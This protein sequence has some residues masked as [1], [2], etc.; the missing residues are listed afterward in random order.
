MST[1]SFQA[2]NRV[3]QAGEALLMRHWPHVVTKHPNG[4]RGVDF[5]DAT[6]ALIELKADSYDM[7]KTPNLFVER[8]SDLMK[9]SPGGPWQAHAKGA[10]VLVYLYSQNRRW[11]VFRDL[12]ALLGRLEALTKGKP[13]TQIP[14]RG[15]ITLGH[16]V[17]RADLQGLYIE[18]ELK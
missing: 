2:Q 7:T 12:P 17:A 10:T 15:Y 14:N 1:W 11:L 3:G 16:K 6:G 8:Y 5:A 18:E 4:I 9:L 13:G